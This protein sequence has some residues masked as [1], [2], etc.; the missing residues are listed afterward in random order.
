MPT[1]G[2]APTPSRTHL[3][4][5]AHTTRPCPCGQLQLLPD[6]AGMRYTIRSGSPVLVVEHDHCEQR[7]CVH[8][9]HVHSQLVH[10]PDEPASITPHARAL[11]GTDPT[12]RALGSQPP[13]LSPNAT[14]APHLDVEVLWHQ[15]LVQLWPPPRAPIQA[16]PRR[17][18]GRAAIGGGFR[19][20][21][22]YPVAHKPSCC[23]RRVGAVD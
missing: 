2:A 13:G 10:F 22:H 19:P 11:T 16:A 21:S 9:R 15:R 1:C 20:C 18:R 6:E 23:T 8:S 5:S 7:V 3:P 4:H 12:S 17:A 14:R